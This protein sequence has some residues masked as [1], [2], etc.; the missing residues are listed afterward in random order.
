VIGAALLATALAGSLMTMVEPSSATL[1]SLATADL[2]SEPE[3]GGIHVRVVTP[4]GPIHLFRPGGFDRRT[5]GIVVY[6]HGYYT[7]VDE[8]WRDHKLADQF[9][10]SRRNA[11]F[12]APEAPATPEEEPSWTTL[13]RLITTVL[14][15]AR[16]PAAPPGPLVVVGHSAAYRTVVP[17][18]DEPSLHQLILVD[19][20]YGNEDEFRDWLA[21]E[22][23]NR[24]TL[25]VKGTTKWADPFVRD[26]PYAVT[27]PKIPSAID[28]LSRSERTAKLLC[29][30]SQY[31]HF[32]LIT[33][34][35]VLPVLLERVGLRSCA[36]RP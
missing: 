15:V 8:A 2:T 12:I 29:L 11:L 7:H 25:V 17:W 30:R 5:A 28:H 24:M 34:G 10:A 18:L 35:K 4:N 19:A 6:V 16:M 23:V 13:R 1:P 31:G 9:A 33:E 14:R 20:M 26:L 27:L 21:R 36:R 3:A 32:E 22:R